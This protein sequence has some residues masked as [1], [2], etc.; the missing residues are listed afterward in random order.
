MKVE[1]VLEGL[2]HMFISSKASSLHHNA[3]LTVLFTSSTVFEDIPTAYSTSFSRRLARRAEKDSRV[4]S[5]TSGFESRC[6]ALRMM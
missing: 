4:V 3:S 1:E 6:A 5:S 2:K